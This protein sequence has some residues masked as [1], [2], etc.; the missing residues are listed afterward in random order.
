MFS[1]P[2]INKTLSVFKQENLNFIDK[3]VSYWFRNTNKF[4]VKH[5][6][7]LDI[8]NMILQYNKF[9]KKFIKIENIS[10]NKYYYKEHL[11][12]KLWVSNYIIQP[13]DFLEI[14]NINFDPIKDCN[15]AY[16]GIRTDNYEYNKK[17]YMS[18]IN[19]MNIYLN[20]KCLYL[21]N[22]KYNNEKITFLLD[23]DYYFYIFINKTNI[24]KIKISI[25]K[26]RFYI[27]ATT[28]YS[29]RHH[30]FYF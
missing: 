24:F 25:N 17:Y 30:K 29:R 11:T 14:I 13:Y 2:I 8:I 23:K 10:L 19:Y 4:K 21:S 12:G 9:Y 3:I 27:Y 22:D 20:N 5:L 28:V 16:I 6:I 1:L 26:Y 15:E 7:P 18:L